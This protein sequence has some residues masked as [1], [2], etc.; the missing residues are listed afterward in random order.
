[1]ESKQQG[2]SWNS[3]VFNLRSAYFSP[4]A[5]LVLGFA[6]WF[7]A[8]LSIHYIWFTGEFSASGIGTLAGYI[9][10][11]V[12]GTC[13][14]PKWL[15]SSLKPVKSVEGSRDEKA[16]QVASV[17]LIALSVIFVTLRFYDI[18]A[19]RSLFAFASAQAARLADLTD[20]V[21]RTTGGISLVSGMG[22]PIA[23]PM[24]MFAVLFQ[25]SLKKWQYY[26]S[27]A[28]FV[29]YALFVVISGNRYILLGPLF[30][31]LTS[32]VLSR[33]SLRISF[34][35]ATIAFAIFAVSFVFITLGTRERDRL[36]GTKSAAETLA[37]MPSRSNYGSTPEFL[38][39][40]QD[41]PEFVQEG[42]L[43]WVNLMW[44]ECHGLYEFQ[45]IGRAHV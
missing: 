2:L 45:K 43:G 40:M 7:I 11:F 42:V 34:R 20:T 18:V 24:M 33:Q 31:V 17:A 39:W 30:L 29:Y 36:F 28:G 21:G 27:V 1:M 38:V 5:M 35:G 37:V 12:I 16:I 8:R 10:F 19:N 44:Y 26:A 32:V 13:L 6:V 23:I 14:V 9:I 3:T 41:Q 22:Y 25:K 4:L 15:T